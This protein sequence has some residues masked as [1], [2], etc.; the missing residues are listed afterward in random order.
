MNHT[1][2]TMESESENNRL[3]VQPAP[4]WSAS[5]SLPGALVRHHSPAGLTRGNMEEGRQRTLWGV[6]SQGAESYDLVSLGVHMSPP[7]GL[8]LPGSQCL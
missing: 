5:F 6:G 8:R 4:W 2:Q 7:S 1:E 3:G